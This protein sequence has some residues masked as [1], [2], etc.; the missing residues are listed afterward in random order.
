MNPL[1]DQIIFRFPEVHSPALD[2]N[3]D[4][5]YSLM[6]MLVEWLGRGQV[7]ADSPEVIE[8][9]KQFIDWCESQPR[10]RTAADDLLTILAVSFYEPLFATEQM[11]RILPRLI[12]QE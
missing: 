7:N 1:Y 11:R 6:T 3:A 2:D 10:G 12:T 4:N 8:R 9:V 5:P